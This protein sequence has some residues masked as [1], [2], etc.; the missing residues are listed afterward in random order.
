MKGKLKPVK[1]YELMGWAKD[2]QHYTELKTV[3]MG[4]S[5]EKLLQLR[6]A[7]DV[8]ADGRIGDQA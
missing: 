7:I 4:E 1:I 5:S 3:R 8:G 2:A 6:Q